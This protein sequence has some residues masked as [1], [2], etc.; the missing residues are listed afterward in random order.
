MKG[1]WLRKSGRGNP[2]VVF[3]HGILSSGE[4]CWRHENGSYWP[5]L[6]KN[7]PG[8]ESLGIYVYSYQTGFASGSY[9]LSDVVDDLKER[10]L[11]LDHVLDSNPI[12]FVCH[13][14]GGIVVRKFIVER[15]QDLLDKKITV[16]LYLVA[17]LL[18]SKLR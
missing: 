2:A 16:G 9:S 10:L 14:M 6:L 3:V 18:F 13:S 12:I 4:K 5:E 1:Q 17:T 7:E 11:N 8:F 15:C